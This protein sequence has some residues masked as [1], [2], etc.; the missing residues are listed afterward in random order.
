M[1]NKIKIWCRSDKIVPNLGAVGSMLEEVALASV[2]LSKDVLGSI[3]NSSSSAIGE[4]KSFRSLTL[5]KLSAKDNGSVSS[6]FILFNLSVCLIQ[7][8]SCVLAG[9]FSPLSGLSELSVT[10]SNRDR[11]RSNSTGNLL[12]AKRAAF[13]TSLSYLYYK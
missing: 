9:R 6:E 10:F 2:S 12:E 7:L 13:F 11:Y 5:E 4:T 3:K 1:H 8:N